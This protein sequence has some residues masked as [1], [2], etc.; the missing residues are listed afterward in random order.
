[1]KRFRFYA[2]CHTEFRKFPLN[3]NFVL[4]EETHEKAWEKIIP[5]ILDYL[6]MR[7]V[8]PSQLDTIELLT[9]EEV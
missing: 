2:R 1:M 9:Y 8:L 7:D 3:L 5:V 4:E 6:Q